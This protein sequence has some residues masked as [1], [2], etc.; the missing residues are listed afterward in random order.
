MKKKPMPVRRAALAVT[1]AFLMVTGT[2]SAFASDVDVSVVDVTAPTGAVALAPGDS[3]PVAI[4]LS[5]TGNQVGTATFEVY[6][7]W[8]LSGGAF[9]G[10]NP[11]EFT[12]GPRAGGSPANVFGTTGTVTVAAGQ[13]AGT[14]TLTVGVFDITNTNT[15]GAKLAAGDSASYSVTV[16]AA[17]DTTAPDI[18]YTL[19]PAAPNGDAGWYTSDVKL[20]WTVADA[21]SA[22]SS[23]TGCED[24]TISA[25]QQATTYTCEATSAGGTESVTTVGI[26]LDAT[27][28]GVTWAGG[29]AEGG[30]YYFG[31]V[32][33]APTCEATDATSGPRDCAVSGHSAAVGNHTLTA[34]AHDNAGNQGT[35]TRSYTVLAWTLKGFYQPVDMN[36]LNIVK[37]GSTVPLKFEVFAGSTELSDVTVVDTFKFGLVACDNFAGDPTDDIEQVTSGSTVLR[38]DTSGG[39]FVQNW[40][41]PKGKAGLC[42]KVV[43]RTDDG[44]DLTA[45]F[46]LK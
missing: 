18:S 12:V 25:D 44:S 27:D 1:T 41:T 10:S 15:T 19:D 46:K 7:N 17:S 39:Q 16:V 2:V 14:F 26:K 34:E 22:I 21:E 29:P 6:R 8:T 11:Q 9:T 3:G 5:V 30:S 4:N 35:E 24:L 32:P 36:A 33:A 38:Y 23:S 28:P 42:Y 40:Q 45:N 31:S 43:M 20:D 37:S 13:A